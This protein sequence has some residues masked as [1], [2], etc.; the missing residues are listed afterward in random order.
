ML[1]LRCVMT[2]FCKF[3]F[4]AFPRLYKPTLCGTIARWRVESP[5]TTDLRNLSAGPRHHE[6][7]I[8][9]ASCL[10]RRIGCP[11]KSIKNAKAGR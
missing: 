1:A 7:V 4:S 6:A 8:F 5:N 11:D 10:H 3:C 9:R 2:S